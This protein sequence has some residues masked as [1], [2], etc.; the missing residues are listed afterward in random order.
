MLP[1]MENN[2]NKLVAEAHLGPTSARRNTQS[3]AVEPTAVLMLNVNKVASMLGIGV[4][5]VWRMV[6]RGELPPPVA[7]GARRLW[8][9]PS[10]EAFIATKVAAAAS[11]VRGRC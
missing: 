1:G 7:L 3:M 4:R 5:T 8:H 6:D 9:R 2:P 10:L 11:A